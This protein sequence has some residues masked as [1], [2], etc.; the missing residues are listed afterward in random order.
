MQRRA[1]KD[2]LEQELEAI[3]S[4]GLALLLPE[5]PEGGAP[6]SQHGT[7]AL[8]DKLP[9]IQI[10]YQRWYTR[11]LPVVQ[12]L[13]PD[14]YDEFRA[15]YHD[16]RRAGGAGYSISDFLLGLAPPRTSPFDARTLFTSKFNHQL[17]I[18]VSA[19]DRLGSV[20]V[21]IEGAVQASL[22]DD[23]LRAARALLDA[24]QVR[25]AGAVAA[26]V[27][28]Q[29]LKIVCAHSGA[30]APLERPTIADYADALKAHGT[31]E[32]NGWRFIR[33]LA[34]IADLCMHER[35]RAPSPS[36]VDEL[37]ADVERA[38]GMVM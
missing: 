21:D 6:G 14:R 1:I 7:P 30:Q 26:V 4:E 12:Q 27:L 32:L 33:H 29:H 13:L 22:F 11:A 17:S 36:E 10:T 5:L 28:T 23:E 15:L 24:K 20:L 35:D 9:P 31:I 18:F 2:K 34:T 19:R 16:E 37:I 8:R 3:Y 25:A 38:L